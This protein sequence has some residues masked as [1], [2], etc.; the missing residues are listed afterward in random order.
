VENQIGNKIKI[1]C[2]DNGDEFTF[3]AFNSFCELHGI[4]Q[5]FRNSYSPQQNGVSKMKK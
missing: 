3:G 2:S 1:F 5:H 4:V